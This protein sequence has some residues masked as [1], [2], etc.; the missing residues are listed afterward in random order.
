[1]PWVL[2]T[3]VS[4]I[5]EELK[6][7]DFAASEGIYGV[8]HVLQL[9]S[10]QT[11]VIKVGHSSYPEQL[12]GGTGTVKRYKRD[13]APLALK[14][15]EAVHIYQTPRR[16]KQVEQELHRQLRIEFG[17]VT[18]HDLKSIELYKSEHV[19]RILVRLREI[20]QRID[21]SSQE[22]QSRPTKKGNISALHKRR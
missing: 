22:M 18:P 21:G 1:M 6:A 13:L 4:K 19:E 7:N 8:V 16:A 10:R 15:V 9:K 17:N 2:N 5:E 12:F 14:K 11:T 20:E 3:L